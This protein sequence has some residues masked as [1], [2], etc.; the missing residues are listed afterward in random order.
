MRLLCCGKA[1]FSPLCLCGH[2]TCQP[3]LPPCQ[4]DGHP[5]AEWTPQQLREALQ[6]DHAYRFLLHDR[7]SIFSRDPDRRIGNL[8]LRVRKHLPGLL[9]PTRSVNGSSGR[10]DAS[11]WT[12]FIPLTENHL[13]RLLREWGRHYNG[14]RP[15]RAPGAWYP[16]ATRSPAGAASRAPTPDVAAPAGG[17]ASGPGRV[18]S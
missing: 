1:T 4:C 18:A 8:G 16:A 10:C 5:T 7:D 9:S 3:P 17:D 13:R 15:L 12:C 2:G 11:V 14:G 6:S